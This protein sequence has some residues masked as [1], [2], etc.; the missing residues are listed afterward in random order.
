MITEQAF[1]HYLTENADMVRLSKLPLNELKNF[2]HDGSVSIDKID[3]QGGTLLHYAAKYNADTSV[4]KFLLEQ[5]IKVNVNDKDGE[6]PLHYAAANNSLTV[7]KFL[8][9]NGAKV[10]VLDKYQRSVIFRSAENPDIEVVKFFEKR[11]VKIDA[12]NTE[13]EMPLHHAARRNPN[14]EVLKFLIKMTDI[15]PK[16]SYETYKLGRSL[17]KCAVLNPNPEI[18]KFLCEEMFDEGLDSGG[19]IAT[20]MSMY[21]D[22]QPLLHAAVAAS[23]TEVVKYLLKRTFDVNRCDPLGRTALDVAKDENIKQILRDAGVKSEKG[24]F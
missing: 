11:G 2:I 24:N 17:I 6:V 10:Y 22:D 21:S 4:L 20:W 8:L 9:E 1:P 23:N 19:N 18:M 12:V 14:V 16:E 5:G 15:A 3:G 7:I 13:G